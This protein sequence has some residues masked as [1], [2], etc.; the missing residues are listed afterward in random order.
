MPDN[1][2]RMKTKMEIKISRKNAKQVKLV[3]QKQKVFKS[4]ASS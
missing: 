1:E 4:V 3:M 2:N